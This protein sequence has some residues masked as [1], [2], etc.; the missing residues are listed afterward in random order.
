MRSAVSYPAREPI[1]KVIDPGA[2]DGGADADLAML[3]MMSVW[4]RV[5]LGAHAGIP[6][7]TRSTTIIHATTPR[8]HPR[9]SLSALHEFISRSVAADMCPRADAWCDCGMRL[10][11]RHNPVD[12]VSA[13]SKWRR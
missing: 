11:G 10:P 3:S 9:T 6:T 8:R 1:G 5:T 7:P 12:P 2:Q 13:R 4:R